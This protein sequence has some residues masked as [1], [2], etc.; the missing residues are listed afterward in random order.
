MALKTMKPATRR[1]RIA[2]QLVDLK[3][4]GALEVLDQV[5][6]G[7]DGATLSGGEAIEELLGAHIELRNRRRLKAA[8]RSSRLPAIKRREDFVMSFQPSLKPEQIDSL[9]ELDFL[10]RQENVVFLGPPGVGKTHLAIALA[11]KAAEQGRRVYFGSLKD[12][13]ESLEEA[14]GGGTLAAATEGPDLS[15]AAGGGRGGVSVADA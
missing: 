9:F 6:S 1:E 11:V 15:A 10:D 2:A 3:L 12:L 5:L 4:P 14:R 7:L 8:V 13:V